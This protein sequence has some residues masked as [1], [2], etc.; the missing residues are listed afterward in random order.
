M[1]V[2]KS[3]LTFFFKSHLAFQNSTCFFCVYFLFLE[4]GIEKDEKSG[5]DHNA[6]I[7]KKIIINLL[8]EHFRILYIFMRTDLGILY[9]SII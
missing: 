1:N 3:L 2:G 4:I 7:T 8:L 5:L 6:L 9:I